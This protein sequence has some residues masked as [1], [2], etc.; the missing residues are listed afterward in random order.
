M[1]VC[2]RGVRRR[3]CPVRV[4]C[5]PPLFV[6]SRAT[7]RRR[8]RVSHPLCDSRAAPCL[9]LHRRR[10]VCARRGRAVPRAAA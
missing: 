7:S 10:R 9:S 4:L 5:F 8:H 1:S 6:A 3:A 2:G